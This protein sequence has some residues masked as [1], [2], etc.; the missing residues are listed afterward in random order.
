MTTL[1]G[2]CRPVRRSVACRKEWAASFHIQSSELMK[3]FYHCVFCR[4][5][6]K[7]VRLQDLTPWHFVL[8]LVG[9]RIH[10]CPHCFGCFFRLR[11]PF[12]SVLMPWKWFGKTPKK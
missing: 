9:L 12:L 11:P 1:D 3:S 5:G 10:R 4:D 6:L 7:P 8:G 2:S